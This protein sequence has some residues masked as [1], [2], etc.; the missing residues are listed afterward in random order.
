LE[1]ERARTALKADGTALARDLA[2]RIL[3]R[4]VQP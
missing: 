1:A 2:G 4:E 3:G